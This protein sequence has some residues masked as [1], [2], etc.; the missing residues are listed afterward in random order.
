M[1]QHLLEALACFEREG[2]AP[3]LARYAALDVLAGRQVRV[4]AGRRIV[5]GLALGLAGDGGLRVATEVGEQ[6][7]HGGEVSVRAR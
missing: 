7:F 1:L 2:L 5:E 6:V 4:L 3:F